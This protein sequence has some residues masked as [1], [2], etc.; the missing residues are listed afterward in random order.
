[1]SVNR[2][3]YLEDHE[4]RAIATI[5]ADRKWSV[6]QTIAEMVREAPTFKSVLELEQV[7]STSENGNCQTVEGG[8]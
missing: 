1:M 2:A 4:D 8:A 5:A 3:T 7:K 6:S